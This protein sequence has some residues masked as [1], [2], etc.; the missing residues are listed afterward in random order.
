MFQGAQ[1]SFTCVH[2]QN[3]VG[4]DRFLRSFVVSKANTSR[5][6]PSNSAPNHVLAVYI[7][8][9]LGRGGGLHYRDGELANIVRHAR[10]DCKT[11]DGECG[12]VSG[13][14]SIT[15]ISRY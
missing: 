9:I 7:L 15:T 12:E 5:A 2:T 4:Y 3:S 10:M 6:L 14:Q 1:S 8:L 11:Q 13:V